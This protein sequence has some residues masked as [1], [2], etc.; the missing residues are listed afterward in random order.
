VGIKDILKQALSR[1]LILE[2]YDLLVARAAC[3]D[4]MIRD[5]ADL[6]AKR[7]RMVVGR[8]RFP[9]QEKSFEDAC[10]ARGGHKLD[11]EVLPGT[12]LKFFQPFFRF[13]TE[14]VG[15]IL[16]FA[17]MPEGNRLPIENISRKAGVS[18]NYELENRFDFDGKG[19]KPDD[20][21][22]LF[23]VARDPDHAGRVSDVAVGVI[24]AEYD[25]YIFYETVEAFL[26]DLG[27]PEPKGEERVPLV[28]LKDPSKER[29]TG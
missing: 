18:L 2:L 23:L 13:P 11:T 1:E 8:V 5:H 24:N 6:D 15:V 22:A 12:D 28:K 27:D 3:A 16:G 26:K 21:Y 7:A 17:S 19:A 20:V 14:K 9:M 10:A 25:A 29:K 4:S